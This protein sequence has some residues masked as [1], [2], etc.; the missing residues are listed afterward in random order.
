MK[1]YLRMLCSA[2]LFSVSAT[3]GAKGTAISVSNEA[4]LKKALRNLKPGSRLS[5]APGRYGGGHSLR[6]VAGRE[7]RPI[8]IEGRDPNNP[9]L[10]AGGKQA[11]HLANCS[12]ITLR[13]LRVAGFPSNGINIDDGGSIETPAHHIVLEDVTIIE[14]GPTGNH[15]ALKLSGVEDFVI[16]NCRFEGWGGSGIDMVGCH[17][18]LIEDCTFIGREGFSQSNGVQ[19]KGGTEDVLVQRCLFRNAGHRSINLGGHT[20]LQ[21]F[22]PRVQGYEAKNITIAG[23]H[24]IGS[25]APVAWAT[26]AGGHVHHNTIILPEKWIIRILQENRDA[27]FS[28]CRDGLFEHNLIIYD[29]RIQHYVNVGPGTAPETFRFHHNAWY[30]LDRYR[31]PVLPVGETEGV[32]LK[33]LS[34][35]RDKLR[36]GALAIN[37]ARLH[38][39]GA[40]AYLPGP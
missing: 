23:N 3:V 27:Q 1:K 31:K 15:D 21:F 14:T 4:E 5:L 19:L 39:I 7:D 34:L 38:G 16:R 33:D 18:G 13:H 28:P 20:G 26:S 22:R 9:P 11:L 29:T 24:F 10:F 6:N 36:E 40:G 2:A 35:D 8:V 37:D 32:Y 17:R 12:H 30:D 25:T